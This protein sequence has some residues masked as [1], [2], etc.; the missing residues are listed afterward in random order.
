[1]E[2]L[3]ADPSLYVRKSVANNLNDISKTHPALVVEIAKDWYGNNEYTDRIVKHGCRTLLK[4]GNKEALE[5]FG[6]SNAES[7]KVT[8]FSL[9]KTSVSVGGNINFS[10]KVAA[11]K[12]TRVRLEYGVDYIKANGMRGRKIYQISEA[13]LAADQ[14]KYYVKGHSFAD[15]SVRRH[16]SG[17]HSLTLIVNGMERGTLDFELKTN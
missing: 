3:K 10:F 15:T 9:D 14:E 7:V 6:L 13:A 1:M 5:I 12:A 11:K 2:R 17:M 8:S 4:K 16:Y